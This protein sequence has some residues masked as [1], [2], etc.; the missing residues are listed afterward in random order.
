MKT[1]FVIFPLLIA[2]S[3][4]S[5]AD[6]LEIKAIN[7]RDA[8]DPTKYFTKKTKQASLCGD[9][10][11]FDNTTAWSPEVADCNKLI[12]KVKDAGKGYY[13]VIFPG[14]SPGVT[15]PSPQS[16]AYSGGNCYFAINGVQEYNW[17]GSQDIQDIITDSITK[18]GQN[19]KIAA[20]GAVP[21]SGG[22]RNEASLTLDWK[23]YGL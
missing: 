10:T 20:S 15:S 6:H 16:L 21:C 11:F 13:T 4:V 3:L 18:F 5:N 22:G 12:E 1:I 14:L 7:A 2:G 17:I 9:S 23:L 8:T 19:G